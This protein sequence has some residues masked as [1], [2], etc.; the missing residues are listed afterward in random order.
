MEKSELSHLG[1]RIDQ[2][3]MELQK[4]VCIMYYHPG[5]L[6]SFEEKKLCLVVETEV[7][8][9]FSGRQQGV[10]LIDVQGRIFEKSYFELVWP[11][12]KY[13]LATEQERQGVIRDIKKKS[14]LFFF[15]YRLKQ[16][17]VSLWSQWQASRIA[18]TKIKSLA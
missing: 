16:L 1:D 15:L 12:M 3:R 4:G 10:S 8:K 11:H 9:T 5:G 18:Y 6:F 13:H 7:I 17:C 2:C 14:S